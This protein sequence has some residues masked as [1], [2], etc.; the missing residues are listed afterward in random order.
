MVFSYHGAPGCDF[1][2]TS[3]KSGF[4]K[5]LQ[6]KRWCPCQERGWTVEQARS[7]HDARKTDDAIIDRPAETG[8]IEPPVY[9]HGSKEER[10]YLAEH[11]SEIFG[12]I[13]NSISEE[14]PDALIHFVQEV[15]CGSRHSKVQNVCSLSSKGHKYLLL[16][17]RDGKPQLETLTGRH[18]VD[19]IVDIAETMM[20]NMG[21]D[22]L[23]AHMSG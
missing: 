21:D 11:A 22:Y 8:P 6:R 12:R 16:E 1:K 5:H 19:R 15:W 18:A 13:R 17:M 4:L 9:A 20:C 7:G 3:S 10:A 23:E 14:S 2:P